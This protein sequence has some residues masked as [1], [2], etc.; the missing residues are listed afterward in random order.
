MC[1]QYTSEQVNKVIMSGRDSY[2]AD[3]RASSLMCPLNFRV[4]KMTESR[5]RFVTQALKKKRRRNRIRL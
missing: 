1:T 5:N 3:A 2:A 4:V